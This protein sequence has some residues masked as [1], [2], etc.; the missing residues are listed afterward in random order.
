MT[1]CLDP[2]LDWDV[3]PLA[4]LFLTSISARRKWLA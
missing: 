3:S 1:V 4:L 2:R